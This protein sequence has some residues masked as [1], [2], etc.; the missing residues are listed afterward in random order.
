LD[1]ASYGDASHIPGYAVRVFT[2]PAEVV[3][4]RRVLGAALGAWRGLGRW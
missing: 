1:P 3:Y 2:V 4:Q